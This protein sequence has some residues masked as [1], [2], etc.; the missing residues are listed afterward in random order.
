MKILHYL[1]ILVFLSSCHLQFGDIDDVRPDYSNSERAMT[2]QFA[3]EDDLGGKDLALLGPGFIGK[4][5]TA[6]VIGEKDKIET[7]IIQYQPKAVR[8]RYEEGADYNYQAVTAAKLKNGIQQ[9]YTLFSPFTLVRSLYADTASILLDYKGLDG[10]FASIRN[11]CDYRWARVSATCDSMSAQGL[12]RADEGAVRLT[13][14]YCTLRLSL[15]DQ[16]GSMTLVQRLRQRAFSE[17]VNCSV[18]SVQVAEVEASE[19]FGDKVYLDLKTGSMML[20]TSGNRSITL[21]DAQERNMIGN[22]IFDIPGGNQADTYGDLSWGTVCYA[23][24]PVVGKTGECPLSLRVI[25]NCKLGNRDVTYHGLLHAG[26]VYQE[27]AEYTTTAIRC[28]TDRELLDE[29]YEADVIPLAVQ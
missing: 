14:K 9:D 11:N 17:G 25:V 18:T 24:F 29:S 3:V 28:V 1:L 12:V 6:K 15:V 27:G 7:V 5:D 4:R 19:N 8:L 20:A 10:T 22:D 23:A 16:D 13:P 21:K 2:F 26:Q